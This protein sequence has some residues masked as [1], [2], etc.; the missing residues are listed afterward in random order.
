MSCS[1]ATL[2][3]TAKLW[4][5]TFS[6]NSRLRDASE[7]PRRA[8]PVFRFIIELTVSTCHRCV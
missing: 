8:E 5:R 6:A 1:V 3:L 4:V 7:R 2:G